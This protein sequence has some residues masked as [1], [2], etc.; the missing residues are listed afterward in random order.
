M[1]VNILVIIKRIAVLTLWFMPL[2]IGLVLA[3]GC[4]LSGQ[5]IPAITS[6]SGPIPSTLGRLCFWSPVSQQAEF[7]AVYQRELAPLLAQH[8]LLLVNEESRETPDSLFCRLFQL[9][10]N[11]QLATIRRRLQQDPAWQKVLQDLATAWG[12]ENGIDYRL[13]SYQTPAGTGKTVVAATGMRQGVWQTFSAQ[14]GLPSANILSQLQ[15]RHGNLW[16]GTEAGVTRFDGLAFTTFTTADGLVDNNVQSI[17]EDSQ[18]RLWFGT[19]TWNRNGS[20][21]S[22]YDGTTFTTFT[23]ADGLAANSVQAIVQDRQGY[24]WFGTGTWRLP[25]KGLSRYDGRRFETFDTDDGLLGNTVPDLYIDERGLLWIATLDWQGPGGGIYT[26]DGSKFVPLEG[27]R[28][29]SITQDRQGHMWFGTGDGVKRYDGHK[30]SSYS[31]NEGLIVSGARA[32]VVDEEDRLWIGA[33]GSGVNRYDGSVFR[34][35]N[36]SDGLGANMIWS[37]LEDR[38]GHIWVSTHGG[39]VSRFLGARFAHVEAALD[40][41]SASFQDRQ[42]HMWLA[43]RGSTRRFD[44]KK[45][46]ANGDGQSLNWGAGSIFEDQQGHIWFGGHNGLVRY[47][48]ETFIPLGPEDMHA[49][50]IVEDRDGA[51]WFGTSWSKKGAMRYDGETFTAL[52][53]EDGL[54]DNGVWA[55]LQDA[56]GY[57][58]F[59]T[60]GGVSRYDGENFQNYTVADGLADNWVRAIVEDQQGRL[61]FGTAGGLHFFADGKFISLA[62]RGDFSSNSI[63]H[64]MED[65][66]GTLWLSEYGGGVSRYDGQVLQ[67]LTR[68]DGLISNAVEHISRDKDNYF[69]IST[70]G[71]V[72]RYRPARIPPSIEIQDVI[73]DRSLGAVDTLRLSSNEGFFIVEFR[74]GSFTTP[75]DGLAYV[76]RLQGHEEAWRT[77][78]VNRVGYTDLPVGD[79]TFQVK[80]VDRDLNYSTS[81]TTVRVF[82]RPPYAQ[83]GLWGGLVLSLVGVVLASAFGIRRQRAQRRAEQNLLRRMEQELEEARQLQLSMLPSEK[84]FHAHIEIA[85]DMLT[86]T[87]VGGDYYD[88]T[89][90]EDGTLTVILGDATGHGMVAGTMVSAT[91][92]L[93][94]NLA[95]QSSITEIF[96][97]MSRS[98]KG[99]QLKRIGMAMN[100]VKIKDRILYASSAGIPPILLYRA[101]TGQVEEILIEGMPL[102]YSVSAEYEQRMFELAPG[103]AVLLMSDGLPERL[104]GADEEYFYTRTK[105]LFAEVATGTPDVIIQR[106]IQGGE[107]WANGRPQDDDITLVVLK[108]KV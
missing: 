1:S 72:T 15:D 104:N 87:E 63:N 82:I 103:D 51:L 39:G 75:A 4:P 99:M 57:M 20:G 8:G 49:K 78:R 61:W 43:A 67:S 60:T 46:T 3:L 76:Y 2:G 12:Q 92:S 9:E 32:L 74:G 56:D 80:A 47:N 70:E 50:Y 21:I 48:G 55:I 34:S 79:Y 69:W 37:M 44:R 26:Y 14:D 105:L 10:A 93:F 38:E 108:M 88:Y 106:L 45:L 6:D 65:P 35:F 84:P 24:M 58:W 25:G 29:L 101:A 42:G 53:T 94:L 13:E 100:M 22:R 66:D 91:K 98:L 31:K 54:V 18:G 81:P 102:G 73:T 96:S 86:A 59:G 5:A 90:S 71:G 77:T 83:I 41:A 64:I 97:A 11:V 33:F 95:H 19:G 27:V 107:E 28:A 17:A 7:A 23:T 52:T 36:S 40:F 16:F 62:G 89:L 85:W 30:I 68:R